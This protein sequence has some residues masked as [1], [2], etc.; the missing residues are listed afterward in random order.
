M[1]LSAENLFRCGHI[2]G[3][4]VCAAEDNLF[5]KANCLPEMRKD[6]VHSLKMVLNANSCDL[7]CRMWMP[8]CSC[9]TRKLQTNWCLFICL[10]RFLQ[11]LVF[12]R[13]LDLY[14]QITGMEQAMWKTCRT[15]SSRPA[16]CMPSRVKT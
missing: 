6:R 16:W 10:S 8:C 1:N 13:V 11:S 2:Q 9:T 7:L 3:I 5:L 4:L 14:R 12:T 15:H